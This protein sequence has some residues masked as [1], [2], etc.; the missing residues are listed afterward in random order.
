MVFR[1]ASCLV[2]C[3]THAFAMT[4]PFDGTWVYRADGQSYMKFEIKTNGTSGTAVVTRPK[5]MNFSQD[6]TMT[7]GGIEYVTG[8]PETTAVEPRALKFIN[9]VVLT[10]VDDRHAT[11][12]LAP[13]IHPLQLVRMPDG[14]TV[15]MA[16]LREW[17]PEIQSLR[18]ELVAL[19][20]ED[21]DAR[22]AFDDKRIVAADTHARSEVVRIMDKYGWVTKS[23]AGSD[24]A[25]DFWLLMQ[26]QDLALQ[27]RGLTAMKKA[28]DSSD[29]SK[30]DYAYLYDR[31][32]SNLGKP[33]H[34]GTQTQC[35]G[36]GPVVLPVDDPAGLDARRAELGLMPEA[37]Y[38]KNEYLVRACGKFA[39]K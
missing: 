25:H 1:I 33:Q 24:A 8:E 26:H 19:V 21:Q 34:W 10:L 11:L 16:T 7:A 36:G 9:G 23:L 30:S 2:F 38:L 22:N 6:G 35:T 39:T 14:E 28:T 18:Q 17:S 37:D 20:K 15:Q 12:T 32:Q 27:Q 3:G 4:S 31:V 29:A 5:Q 13:Q